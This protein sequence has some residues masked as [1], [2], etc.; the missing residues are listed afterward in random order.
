MT[1]V[2][3]HSKGRGFAFGTKNKPKP[4]V[5]VPASKPAK[6]EAPAKPLADDVVVTDKPKSYFGNTKSGD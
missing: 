4:V 6:V 3:Y 1:D 2:T 5:T